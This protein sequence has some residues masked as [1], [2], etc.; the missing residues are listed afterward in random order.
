MQTRQVKSNMYLSDKGRGATPSR[1]PWPEL[2]GSFGGYKKVLSPRHGAHE[3]RPTVGSW[4]GSP[5]SRYQ[6]AGTSERMLVSSCSSN[7]AATLAVDR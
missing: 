5:H 6:T 7:V 1:A 3:T 2:E 4:Q